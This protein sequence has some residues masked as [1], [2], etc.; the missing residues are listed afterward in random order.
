[1]IWKWHGGSA[2][3]EKR[4]D[5]RCV[6]ASTIESAAGRADPWSVPGMILT[7]KSRRAE[8]LKNWCY[9]MFAMMQTASR[10]LRSFLAAE[11]RAR[12]DIA[13]REGEAASQGGAP[14]RSERVPVYVFRA[15]G[16]AVMSAAPRDVVASVYGGGGMWD[17][18]GLNAAFGGGCVFRNDDTGAYF[19]GVWGARNASR[20][21][22]ALR[23]GGVDL[24][25][26]RGPPPARLIVWSAGGIRPKPCG[27]PAG[28]P[29]D[30]LGGPE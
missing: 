22:G 10:Q 15:R 6:C 11:S 8:S 18:G 30:A 14:R 3:R 19:L 1:M 27:H 2:E 28:K 25:I 29:P 21:R 9:S 7:Q 26:V 23:R 5:R 13:G 4:R 17:S 12:R 16:N 20:F 24:D